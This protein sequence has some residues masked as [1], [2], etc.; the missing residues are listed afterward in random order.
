M[1]LANAAISALLNLVILGGLPFLAYYAYQKWRHKRG[2]KEVAQRA[3]LQLGG[4]RYVG[5][6]LAV[7]LATAAALALWPPPLEPF[8]REGSPQ[9][10]FVGLGLSGQAVG[11]ALLYGVLQ[12]GFTEELLFRG[13]I[14]GSLARRL[15]GAWA[16][17]LQAL[18][19]LAPHLLVL[20]I[21]PE[22]WWVIPIVFAFAL[23][24]G[25]LRIRSD[26]II[27]PW[28]IHASVNVST[29]LSVAARTGATS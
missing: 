23:F 11:M 29:C 16:N 20:L 12:T 17:L 10:P 7:A 19:F 14:A 15:P 9:Q 6:G 22:M 8:L 27:G 4:G 26:S 21:M 1:P 13:L 24:A 25:W 3:G 2:F 28:L 18:I 5:Y